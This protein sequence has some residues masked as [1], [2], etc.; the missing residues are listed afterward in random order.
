MS[1]FKSLEFYLSYPFVQY[2]LVVG[3]LI[4][5]CSSLLGVTL[6]LKRFSLL[7]DGLSHVAFGALSVATILKLVV[8]MLFVLPVTV[9]CAVCLLCASSQSRIRGDSFI[10]ML[11]VSS[12]AIGYMLVNVFAS[13]A[14]VS[15]DVC[16]TLF[17]STS[18]LTLT[19][20]DVWL[21]IIL[22]LGVV[23]FFVLFY[24]RIFA[25]TFDETF[26]RATG[27]PVGFCN[28]ILAVVVAVIIV[29]AMN[30]VGS[31]LI[32]ALVVF[33]A[34][35]AMRICRSFLGVTICAAVLSVFCAFV[36]ML[37]AIV[38]GT[39]VGAT[40]VMVDLVAFLLSALGSEIVRSLSRKTIATFL[41]LCL[42][43]C[44]LVSCGE[45]K[46]AATADEEQKANNV[47][48]ATVD[49]EKDAENAKI[50]LD[51]TQLNQM[52]VYTQVFYM[53]QKP[54]YYAGQVIRMSGKCTVTKNRT[55]QE[56][57]FYCNISDST[58]CCAA[59]I[60]FYLADKEK[61]QP[62][63]GDLITIRGHFELMPDGS[64]SIGV[65]QEAV[66]E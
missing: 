18:I 38:A 6:V 60:R 16:S 21:S 30:L 3:V 9:L 23:V 15:A 57:L 42:I 35:S 39:P 66:L 12:L 59:M 31:L 64:K 33:P 1:I 65:L 50:D 10:A 4:A 37:I 53:L 62:R 52:M 40:I 56:R 24:D 46:N 19:I 29:L 63:P 13:S 55:T 28:L 20:H 41:L 11:S 49:E 14:N 2:A 44:L 61:H 48:V 25:L 17:G 26:A 7:G 5:L 43:S 34:L 51:L 27:V 22:S 36:G 58:G 8:P 54:Q 47:N 45:K 32:S